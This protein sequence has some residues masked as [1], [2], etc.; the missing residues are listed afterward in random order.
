MQNN[1]STFI[2]D[3]TLFLKQ[4]CSTHLKDKL[5]NWEEITKKITY[6]LVTAIEEDRGGQ[7]VYI[8]LNS[9]TRKLRIYNDFNGSNYKELARK[10]KISLNQIRRIIN[11]IQKE[12]QKNKPIQ[13]SLF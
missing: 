7:A 1:D 6:D 3:I 4:A 11:E 9:P 10:Y 13:F 5:E 8:Q 12:K 2:D